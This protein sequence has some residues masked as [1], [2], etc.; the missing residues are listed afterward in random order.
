MTGTAQNM[1]AGHDIFCPIDFHQRREEYELNLKICFFEPLWQ[2]KK[3]NN[4]ASL[5]TTIQI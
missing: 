3:C 4:E 5:A 1:E 2:T